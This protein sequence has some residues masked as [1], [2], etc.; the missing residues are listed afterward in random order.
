MGLSS[1]DSG[2][3]RATL[4][5]FA[6]SGGTVHATGHTVAGIVVVASFSCYVA[7]S[8]V[9]ACRA[10]HPWCSVCLRTPKEVTLWWAFYLFSVSATGNVVNWTIAGAVF[11][12]GLFLPPGKQLPLSLTCCSLSALTAECLTIEAPVAQERAWM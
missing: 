9:V 6:V 8:H 10:R 5:T 12:A 11:L 7:H 3:T 2:L 1:R 4:T